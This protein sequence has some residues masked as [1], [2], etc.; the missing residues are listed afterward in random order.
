M[1]KHKLKILFSALLSAILLTHASTSPSTSPRSDS[2]LSSLIAP[3]LEPLPGR[4][5]SLTAKKMLFIA[6]YALGPSW[7]TDKPAHEQA[8]FKA[9]SENL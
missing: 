7:Q 6:I 4:Q 8:H 9:H 1:I 3:Q 5:D 2:A